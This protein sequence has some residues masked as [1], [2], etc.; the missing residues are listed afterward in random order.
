VSKQKRD[1]LIVGTPHK[2]AADTNLLRLLLGGKHAFDAVA[3]LATHRQ[4]MPTAAM[5]ASLA[6]TNMPRDQLEH[7]G[8]MISLNYAAKL[9]IGESV[10]DDM[11]ELIVA[12]YERQLAA[13]KTGRGRPATNPVRNFAVVWEIIERRIREPRAQQ[14]AIV[15]DVAKEYGIERSQ[16]YK[17]LEDVPVEQI[18]EAGNRS[19]S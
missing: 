4:V 19:E 18:I 13:K 11:K 10:G 15:F 5:D 9:I 14:K 16:I 2:D 12:W 7:A 6:V 1:W 17:L 3:A 8:N